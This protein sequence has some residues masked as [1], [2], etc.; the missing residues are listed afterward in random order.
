M[1]ATRMSFLALL[2]ATGACGSVPGEDDG[3]DGGPDSSMQQPVTT[4]Y[5][6]ALAASPVVPFVNRQPTY[7]CA[8][9][10]V[11]K[12]IELALTISSTGQI[13]GGTAS[14][15]TEEKVTNPGSTPDTCPYAPA[16]PT[17]LKFNFKSATPVGA[18]T[19]VVMEGEAANSPKS[20]LAITLTPS[21][22]AFSA[23]ARWTRTDQ[24]PVLNWSVTANLTL[25][26]K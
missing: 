8:Y 21:A 4:T 3:V 1:S 14:N 11:L 20:T 15:T 7:V 10:I 16:G 24:I 13:T 2:V 5:G 25:T 23:A 18:S 26:A 12:S 22:G 17:T 19:M 9:T 6:G